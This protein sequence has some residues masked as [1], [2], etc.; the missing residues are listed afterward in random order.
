MIIL[1]MMQQ[2]RLLHSEKYGSSKYAGIIGLDADFNGKIIGKDFKDLKCT[3]L[4]GYY[5]AGGSGDKN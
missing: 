4:S 5:Q 3:T 1:L 2:R